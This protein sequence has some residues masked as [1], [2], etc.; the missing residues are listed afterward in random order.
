MKTVSEFN[1]IMEEV[2]DIKPEKI[3]IVTNRGLFEYEVLNDLKF[4]L[5][6][7]LTITNSNITG[8]VNGDILKEIEGEEIESNED[9][10][11]IRYNLLPSNKLKI[12]SNLRDYAFLIREEPS[13]EVKVPSKNN[14]KKGLELEGGTRVLL[15][16]IGE[17]K[18]SS[19]D[20]G[21]LITVLRN[22]LNI[23]GLTDLK[24]REASAGDERFVL[25]EIAGVSKEEIEGFISQQGKFEANIGNETVFRGGKDDIPFVCRDDGSCS[26]VHGCSG[27]T[28]GYACRFQFTIKLSVDAAQKH[29]DVTRDLGVITTEGGQNIL[30]EQIEFYLDGTLIDSLNV[31]AS[32]K[33]STNTE[34][35]ISGPGFGNTEQAAIDDAVKNM[36]ELQTVL[37]TGSLPYKLEIVKLESISPVF[38]QN[39][40]K[41]IFLVGIASLL[42]VLAVIYIRYRNVRV[43]LP[44]AITL[45]SEILIILGLAAFIGWNLDLAAIAG[46]IAAVGT[47]VDDQIVITDEIMKGQRERFFSWK[48]KIKRAFYII[49]VAYFSTVVAMMPLW[50]AAAGLLRGFAITTILG[51]SIGVLVTR[52]AFAAMLERFVKE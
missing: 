12:K 42:S 25:V 49:L 50:G 47:G 33:G 32:L 15:Q 36:E 43:L 2:G 22:K 26:G 14:I 28:G 29:A 31:D 18:V 21:D 16:P 17:S 5:G 34:I 40:I 8:V 30:T 41:N 1:S 9:F 48:E 38:G 45:V 37:I 11:E 51:V 6:E 52:P 19:K 7:N 10:E 44:M 13:I 35:Q 20:I 24:M 27:D 3:T 46:I 39:L 4:S 23:Y